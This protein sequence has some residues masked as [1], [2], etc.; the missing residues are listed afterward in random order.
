MLLT[1]SLALVFTSVLAAS[2]LVLHRRLA[3][4]LNL[5]N[6]QLTLGQLE[7]LEMRMKLANILFVM[8]E[9]YGGIAKQVVE[10]AT[11]ADL[12]HSEVPGLFAKH[13]SLPY[14]LHSQS[15][16]LQELA[17][18][19]SSGLTPWQQR[20]LEDSR[21]SDPERVFAQIFVDSSIPFPPGL[22]GNLP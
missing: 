12:I 7:R 22:V 1:L 18:A 8:N 21:T 10:R 4:A 5:A 16:F 19:T 11:I 15:Q 20:I 9:K 2:L 14:M 3:Q 6:E 13:K 17:D